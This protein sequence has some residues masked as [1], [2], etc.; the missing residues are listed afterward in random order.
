MQY[1]N[2]DENDFS[3][4]IDARS[5]EN[6]IEK[7]FARDLLNA[8]IV[9]K[10]PRTRPGAQGFAGNVPVRVTGMQYVDS[11]NQICFTLD[12]AVVL[13]DAAVDLTAIRSTPIVVYGRSSSVAS[14]GP[15]TTAGDSVRYYTGF[16][17]ETRKTFL[18]TASAPPFESITILQSE[19]GIATTD[20]FVTTVEATDPSNLSYSLALPHEIAIDETTADLTIQYQNS[21]GTDRDVFVYYKDQTPV[22]G[23]SYVATLNHT[24]SGSETFTIPVGT[25][26]LSSGNIIIQVQQDT[27]TS[28]V[29]VRANT[30]QIASNGDVSLT[31]TSSS[32]A[33]FYCI[34]AAA[35][36][37]NQVTGNIAAATTDTI[38]LPNLT[39]P[40]IFYGIYVELTPGG[41][42]ELVYPDS[43]SYDATTATATLTFT[44][45]M[46]T[47]GN[48]VVFW[49]YG[50]IR[51]NQLC[52]TDTSVTVD[53]TDTRPQLTIWGLD[54]SE[55]YGAGI[56]GRNG[57]VNHVDSYRSVGENRLI[58]GLGGNLFNAR[59]Y[60]EAAVTYDYAKLYPRLQARTAGSTVL[61]PLFWE[62]GDTP[63][64]ARGYVTS[65]DSGTGW[66]RVTA[67]A[68]DSGNGWTKYTCSVPNKQVLDS[69]GVPISLL[70]VISTTS[71]L[72]DWF[73]VE[74]MSYHLHNGSFRI[75]Q[76][77]D[78]IDEITVWVENEDNSSDWDDSGVSGQAGVFTDQITWLT[79]S[80]FIP[81][82]S[83][84]NAALGGTFNSTVKSSL[85][86]VSVVDSIIE[87][88]NLAGGILT[89]GARTS[90]VVSLRS[91]QPSTSASTTNLVRG[92]MLS[93]TGIERLLRVLYIN[94]E[95]DHAVTI[96]VDGS[97]AT[98]TLTSG[99]TSFLNIGRSILLTGAGVFS[100]TQTITSIPTLTTFT[101]DSTET[102]GGSGTVL[103]NTMQVDEELEWS[104]STA[105][106]NLFRVEERWIP[107]E[108][109]DD[110]YDLTPSTHVRYFDS[111]SYGDQPFLRSTMVAN[112]MY[113]TDGEDEVLKYDGESLY[114]AGLFPWQAGLFL[115]QDTA[116][117][118]K[119]VVDNPSSTPT[120]VVNNVFTLPL[121]DDNKF[122][123]GKRVRHSFT[124]GFNDY[125]VLAAWDDASNSFVKVQRISTTAIT[126]GAAPVLTLLSTLRYYFRLNAVDANDNIVASAVTG[127]QD[128]VVE[129][130]ADAAVN[131][132]AVGLP[133]WDVLDYDRLELEIYRTRINTSAP[134]YKVT[135]Q[136]MSFNNTLGYINY[137]DS[138]ADTDLI[139]LDAVSTALKGQ[140][141]GTAWQEPLRAKYITSI[142][143]SLVLA[144]LKDYPQLD[145]QLIASGAVTNSTYAGKRFLFRK[146]SSDTG[147]T[148]DMVNRAAYEFVETSTAGV[149]TAALGAAGSFF[150]VAVPNTAV[151]GDWVYLFWDT[152]ATSGRPMKYAGWWQVQSAGPT[153]VTINFSDADAGGI[154]TLVP[155]RALFATDPTDIPIPL[156]VDGNLGQ[157]NGDSFDLFD[158]MRRM[159]M[160][161]NSSMRM[162]DVTITG[163]SDFVPWMIS[164]GGNDVGK[165]GRLIVRQPRVEATLFEVLLPS[166]FSGGGQSFQVFVND[167]RRLAAT[168]VIATTRLYS[169]RIMVSYENYPEIFDNPTS[170]LDTDS[171]SA[172][173]VNPADGQ[174]ITGVLPFFGEA[175]FTAAQQAAILVVF[176]TNSIYL[177][178]INEKRA[179]RNPIQRIETE[180]LGCTAPYSIAVTKNGICFANESGMYCL[181][182]DQK[183]QYIGR[184]M[185]RNWGERV[186]LDQLT[187]CQ[188][189][190]YGVGRSYKLSVPLVGSTANSEVYVYNHT[191]EDEGRLG[192]WTRYD[193]HPV[194][195]WAN[196]AADAFWASTLGR[197]FSI[198]NTGTATDCRDDSSPILFQVD[199][200]AMDFGNP[201][202]RKVIDA[203]IVNY[204]TTA[205][206]TSAAFSYSMDLSQ[207]YSPTTS[208]TL[209]N[210]VE[211][212]GIDDVSAHDILPVLHKT[213]RRKGIFFQARIS[214]S[215]LDEP[216][217][218]A[219][220]TFK[221][222]GLSEKGIRQAAQAQ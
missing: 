136:L 70:S 118:A 91:G 39:S 177:V 181:R 22:A 178:D 180:G 23:S 210:P 211:S 42:K 57:W 105:D 109:P 81:G 43:V 54:H 174:D 108:A 74:D 138:F 47:A 18:A 65:T 209:I 121:G 208:I 130:A 21:T 55:I 155:N 120:A 16:S 197:I 5:A 198:R 135:T 85:S 115:T 143:N 86:T 132:K 144:H 71:G 139:D 102:V 68:Y 79:S 89:T 50:F 212:T 129:L 72:E 64:R 146:D 148:T 83:L 49:D 10:R 31:L 87:R 222:G 122:P 110:S 103:G 40:W 114:R 24:G 217:E 188:G 134:F 1:I 73:Q 37:A 45:G 192:A 41:T 137:T 161:I 167:V 99:D 221:V 183:I 172:I 6:Q 168:P 26:A 3:L 67:V 32:P 149:V 150:I 154:L 58:S 173:D 62:T 186:D 159:S 101:F 80:P 77:L 156:G 127:Y 185:E 112:N 175:T 184:Y 97:E 182:R 124:G 61:G 171:D 8:D 19:H 123:V 35:S 14:G 93:F 53:A 152:V 117:T 20:M 131:I 213:D 60:D 153:D 90:S 119:I 30:A 142:G 190:H 162:V 69:A 179:G 33:T 82:D 158:T 7:G 113:L 13:S 95:S 163:M 46:A 128:H 84:S 66:V 44:N 206:I 96:A 220:I 133:A 160:A 164:R 189:H 201:G 36:V 2:A 176:K 126:L 199:T 204:R 100:G 203:S 166:S 107:I 125:N 191:G 170:V 169:S 219:G 111:S 104:D 151:A 25:H 27:G 4:G 78:G 94:P 205:V 12:S 147:P 76:V 9:E 215:S 51:S 214:C 29:I 207:Q 194:T 218:V 56:T 202:I 216:L 116:A 106:A 195:G 63:A 187:I 75:R 28:R 92:D 38:L 193:N 200:R 34:L 59:T 17:V 157:V 165:A 98:A 15:F 11:T 141:L 88:L 140:E 196:L 48:F 52:V 145:I